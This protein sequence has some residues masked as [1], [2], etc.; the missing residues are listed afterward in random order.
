MRKGGVRVGGNGRQVKR[1][2]S[3]LG[4]RIPYCGSSIAAR[5]NDWHLAR[6]GIGGDYGLRQQ[7]TELYDCFEG[8]HGSS[9]IS[10]PVVLFSQFAGVNE[11]M[12]ARGLGGG[13][14]GCCP[15]FS[16]HQ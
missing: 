15:G 10:H 12:K 1:L 14:F 3:R 6:W 4:C 2:N 5:R 13:N 11:L 9:E 7:Q 8:E 16:Q